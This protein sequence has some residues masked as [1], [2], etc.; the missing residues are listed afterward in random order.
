VSD[1]AADTTE[2]MDHL[3][4]A[5]AQAETVAG[6]KCPT[7]EVERRIALAGVHA[8]IAMAEELRKLTTMLGRSTDGNYATVTIDGHVTT[9]AP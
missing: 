5:R 9:G 2:P 6:H 1:Q 7:G 8:N 4:E 3:K